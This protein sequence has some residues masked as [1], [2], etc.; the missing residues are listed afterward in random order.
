[1]NR[2][3]RPALIASLIS[4]VLLLVA[5]SKGGEKPTEPAVKGD[6][7]AGK[8]AAAKAKADPSTSV[9]PVAN[10]DPAQKPVTSN[11]ET[12]LNPQD[13]GKRWRQCVAR[14]NATW[15]RGHRDLVART[16]AARRA[17]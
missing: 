14:T 4:I 7:T 11:N 13:F 10:T 1:M 2:T 3:A 17:G 5:C 15:S 8:D 12:Q 9:D 16:S 6:P